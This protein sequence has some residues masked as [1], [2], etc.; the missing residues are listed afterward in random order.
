[1]C[2]RDRWRRPGRRP[3]P[4]RGLPKSLS[5]PGGAR[6]RHGGRVEVRGLPACRPEPPAGDAPM[7]ALAE[8]YKVPAPGLV[9]PL[10]GA[11]QVVRE[12]LREPFAGELDVEATLEN[13]LGKTYPE[14]G[15][16]IV[17]HL[18]LIH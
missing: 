7:V 11:T 6:L 8:R 5:A 16:W 9:G 15:D 18:S 2:I 10:R 17:Q 14:P 13:V 3:G 1:M 12:T 4:R